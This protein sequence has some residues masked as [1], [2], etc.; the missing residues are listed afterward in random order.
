LRIELIEHCVN[1]KQTL[2]PS[3]FIFSHFLSHALNRAL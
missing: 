2:A 3:E 1:G